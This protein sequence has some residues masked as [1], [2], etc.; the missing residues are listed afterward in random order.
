MAVYNLF[1]QQTFLVHTIYVRFNNEKIGTFSTKEPLICYWRT[2]QEHPTGSMAVMRKDSEKGI[3]IY[4][5]TW[6]RTCTRQVKAKIH[7]KRESSLKQHAQ[8]A[9]NE[10]ELGYKKKFK[11]TMARVVGYKM[12][13]WQVRL[14]IQAGAK[15]MRLSSFIQRTVG[16][17][18]I[19]W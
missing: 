17:S 4:A 19:I 1:I 18:R 8:E 11:F 10:Q 6:G 12:E 16:S 2:K 14:E 15:Y 3:T 7:R 13:S 9:Q 5:K